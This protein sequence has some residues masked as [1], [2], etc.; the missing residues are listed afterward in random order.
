MSFRPGWGARILSPPYQLLSGSQRSPALGCVSPAGHLKILG[1][2]P[3]VTPEICECFV[4]HSSGVQRRRQNNLWGRAQGA[5]SKDDLS[6]GLLEEGQP[7]LHPGKHPKS[8]GNTIRASSTP[9][10][11]WIGF[12][13]HCNHLQTPWNKT[14][15]SLLLLLLLKE[16]K[17]HGGGAVR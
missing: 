15:I 13:S 3:T 1:E 6:E 10:K 17:S 11:S 8:R 2:G 5:E 16:Q 14:S 4:L 12:T 9:R 7:G